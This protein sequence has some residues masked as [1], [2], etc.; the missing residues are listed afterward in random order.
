[1]EDY[2]VLTIFSRLQVAR[3]VQ[4]VI[5]KTV[6]QALRSWIRVLQ[7]IISFEKSLTLLK[8]ER[9][10]ESIICFFPS[11]RRNTTFNSDA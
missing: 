2:N 7:E 5:P 3:S 11:T 8:R 6:G 1:M 9:E 10:R 4:L